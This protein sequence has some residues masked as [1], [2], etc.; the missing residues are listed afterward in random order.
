MLISIIFFLIA[1][2]I[3][4]LFGYKKPR[5]SFVLIL[6]ISFLLVLIYILVTDNYDLHA[7]F[8]P[9]FILMY[10]VLVLSGIQCSPRK[11]LFDN[12]AQFLTKWI[13]MILFFLLISLLFLSVSWLLF[14]FGGFFISL[15]VRH[16]WIAKRNNVSH[17]LLEIAATVR[18]NMPLAF[19]L[20]MAAVS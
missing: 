14:I 20:S 9:F 15:L 18:Q 10:P 13:L 11:K 4:V 19:G 12:W 16:I 1:L 7:E 5:M 6:P 17:V 2:G 3:G 8:I